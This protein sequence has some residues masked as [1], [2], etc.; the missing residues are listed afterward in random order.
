[1]QNPSQFSV[2]I[3]TIADELRQIGLAEAA[4]LLSPVGSF[5]SFQFAPLDPQHQGA[6]L[7]A[8]VG[9]ERHAAAAA[10]FLHIQV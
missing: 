8:K 10:Q 4:H 1:M 2:Q 3:S 7:L 6:C 5:V 9:T